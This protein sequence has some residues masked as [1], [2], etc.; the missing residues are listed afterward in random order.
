MFFFF[1]FSYHAKGLTPSNLR[2]RAAAGVLEQGFILII[3]F[4][5]QLTQ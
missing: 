1:F 5:G 2:F 3:D 4:L